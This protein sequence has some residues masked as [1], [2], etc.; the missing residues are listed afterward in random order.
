M[1]SI[2]RGDGVGAN[3]N[4][5]ELLSGRSPRWISRWIVSPLII[6]LDPYPLLTS[7]RLVRLYVPYS[8]GLS[9]VASRAG[10]GSWIA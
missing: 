1:T 7:V 4:L 8:T 2:P 9:S 10:H 5:L 3:A 6:G